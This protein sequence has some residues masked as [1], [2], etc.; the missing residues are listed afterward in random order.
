MDGKGCSPSEFIAE[1]AGGMGSAL[2]VAVLVGGKP[3]D[4]VNM[5]VGTM[6][7]IIIPTRV[8]EP[9]FAKAGINRALFLGWYWNDEYDQDGDGLTTMDT[10]NTGWSVNDGYPHLGTSL[11]L[12]P[13]RPASWPDA[14]VRIRHYVSNARHFHSATV[15]SRS[16][17]TG[18]TFKLY[19]TYTGTTLRGA[20]MA[21]ERNNLDGP[22]WVSPVEP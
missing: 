2:S 18:Q 15:V 9:R 4:F 17:L 7:S 1:Q 3:F 13:L 19:L 5:T 10:A 21:R 20:R 14:H 12:T 16:A 6:F 8:E 11:S 22:A